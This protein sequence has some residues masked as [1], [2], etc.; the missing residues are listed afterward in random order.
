MNRSRLR[1][2]RSIAW[3]TLTLSGGTSEEL[4]TDETSSASK[5]ETWRPVL[6]APLL[7]VGTGELAGNL[8]QSQ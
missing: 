1:T 6:E 4:W 8:S 5:G 3:R 2:L 7:I